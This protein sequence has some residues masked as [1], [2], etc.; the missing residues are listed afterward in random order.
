MGFLRRFQ[1]YARGIPS[2]DTL[3]DVIAAIDPELFKA[4][5]LAWVEDL[6]ADTA[7]VVVPPG[8]PEVNAIDGKTSP[9]SHTRAKGLAPLHTISAWA[10]R[11]RLVFGQEAVAEKSNEITAISGLLRRLEMTGAVVTIDAIG[12]TR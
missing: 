5:F 8:V 10:A 6:R 3:C 4:C 12:T 1:P 9:R 7:D 2:H 11:Q